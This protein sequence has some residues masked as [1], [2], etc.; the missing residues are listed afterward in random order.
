M[1]TLK[2]KE[3][4]P[5]VQ[6]QP[7][8]PAEDYLYKKY[9]Q[10]MAAQTTSIAPDDQVFNVAIFGL[11]RAGT[12]HLEHVVSNPRTK[13]VYI[14]DDV[15]S[16]W[17]AIKQYWRLK[18]VTFLTSKQSDLVFKDSRVDIIV[19]ASPTRTHEYIITKCLEAKKAVFCEKPIAED[20]RSIMK[21]YD[22][23]KKVGKPLFCAF[24]RR[25]DPSFIEVRNRIQRGEVGHVHVIKTTS[26]DSPLPTIEYLSTSGGIFHDCMVHDI[27]L[28][29]WVLGEY[30]QKVSVGATAHIPEIKALNDFDT[31]VATLYFA[32]GT[33]GQIDLSRNSNYG[34]DMRLEVF[35]PKGMVDASNEQP[36]H[37][38]TRQNGLEGP[39]KT[40]IWYSFPSRFKLA[41]VT[42]FELFL[43]VV[44]GKKE[45]PIKANDFIA[46][47]K[48]ATACEESAR[49][50]KIITLNWKKEELPL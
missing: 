44:M 37:S 18:D 29:T 35:G 36:I 48:I 3:T 8:A 42:E 25:F 45:L 6:R 46:I 27:D 9:L 22:I 31:V 15:E 33:L 41:Y 2:F 34:Y 12:I 39:Q 23:A 40:P 11:G 49:T 5:Y 4:S 13:V 19:V 10:N 17:E 24:N 47:N 30:P 14:V 1:A 20:D 32:S 21:C 50:G 16:K 28:M 7:E 38:V 26:R 43:D